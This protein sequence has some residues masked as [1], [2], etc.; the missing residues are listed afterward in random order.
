MEPT[1]PDGCSILIDRSRTSKAHKK[2]YVLHTEDGLV[3]KRLCRVTTGWLI[4][5]DHPEWRPVPWSRSDEV[6]GQVR[7]TGRVL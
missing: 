6:I 7:W 2:I 3:V 4:V 1:L 5:S